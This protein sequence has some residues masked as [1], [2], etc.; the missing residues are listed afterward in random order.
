M[1]VIFVLAVIVLY[2]MTHGL[3]WAIDRIRGAQ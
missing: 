3:I 1:D 2:A